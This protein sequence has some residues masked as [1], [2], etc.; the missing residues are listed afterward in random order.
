MVDAIVLAAMEAGGALPAAGTPD[1]AFF[2]RAAAAAFERARGLGLSVEEVDEA[3]SRRPPRPA[4]SLSV[5]AGTPGKK[6]ERRPGRSK[7]DMG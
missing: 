7:R 1:L 2:R 5:V 6:T 4:A 3:L